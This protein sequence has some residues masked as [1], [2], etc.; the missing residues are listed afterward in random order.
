MTNVDDIAIA[1]NVQELIDAIDAQNRLGTLRPDLLKETIERC[2]R[3][4][5]IDGMADELWRRN[6]AHNG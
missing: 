2:Y 3:Y 6:E 5:F 4:G 1:P